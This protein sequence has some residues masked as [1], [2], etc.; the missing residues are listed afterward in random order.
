MISRQIGL[1]DSNLKCNMIIKLRVGNREET[2][3][4]MI[5][6]SDISEWLCCG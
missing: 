5:F 3:V 2:R 6:G 4:E 1:L